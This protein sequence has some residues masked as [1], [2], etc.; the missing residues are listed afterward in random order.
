[1][2]LGLWID[3]TTPLP[4]ILDAV[5]HAAADGFARAWLNESTGW[6]PLTV[7][8]A[9]GERA[10]GIELGTSVVPL[11]PRHPFTLAA[12]A[13]TA[14]AAVGG[15]LTLG[16]GPSHAALV[17]ARFGLP[18]DRPLR[19]VH[20]YLDVLD[21][22]LRGAEAEVRGET[23]TAVGGV[24]APGTK[25]PPVLLAAHGPKML[26]LAGERADG[27]LTIWTGPRLLADYVVP[28]V[29]AGA[30]GRAAPPRITVGVMAS[31]T[32]DPDGVRAGVAGTYGMAGTLPS[33]RGTLDRQGIGGPEETL[34]AGDEA[35]VEAAVRR[36]AE[37][38]ATELMLFP[39][40][41]PADRARTVALFA[42]LAGRSG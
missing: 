9:L 1:M 10:P 38:G 42:E 3:G 27:V 12:Q 14:Q 36:F 6:D 22:V 35:V 16:V 11:F 17:E 31:V 40:G 7:F 39:E 15:R 24:A 5:E 13:L 29:T 23:V 21:P 41:S 2:E 37:A 20:E 33:Y 4:D 25:A 30:A 18:W 26:A 34:V 19:R 28:G 32:A 8:A